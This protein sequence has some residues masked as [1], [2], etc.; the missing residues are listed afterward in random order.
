MFLHSCRQVQAWTWNGTLPDRTVTLMGSSVFK[1]E[2]K[3]DARRISVSSFSCCSRS[4]VKP[5]LLWV[6]VH[7]AAVRSSV[8]RADFFFLSLF[9]LWRPKSPESRRSKFMWQKLTFTFRVK[10]K[11]CTTHLQKKGKWT[12][13]GPQ[14]S[15]LSNDWRAHVVDAL[16]Q[17]T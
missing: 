2:M 10:S 6:H 14:C 16:I 1:A 11:L 9:F 5:C 15:Q 17:N 12:S 7:A 3:Q 13:P 8:V 4:E